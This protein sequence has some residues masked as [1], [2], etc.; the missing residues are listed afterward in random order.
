MNVYDYPPAG[1]RRQTSTQFVTWRHMASHHVTPR[2]TASHRRDRAIAGLKASRHGSG[3]SS[4][5]SRN[6]I[7]IAAWIRTHQ[8]HS[9]VISNA[10]HTS[11]TTSKPVGGKSR[12]TA[13][14]PAG[15]RHH[16]RHR[17]QIRNRIAQRAREAPCFRRLHADFGEQQRKRLRL[18]IDGR[19]E[20]ASTRPAPRSTARRAASARTA[21]IERG[22]RSRTARHTTRPGRSRRQ[23]PDSPRSAR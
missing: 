8:R 4:S 18:A 11:T 10:A 22:K 20:T 13:R 12:R 21:S 5:V 14:P 16:R 19:R 2:H 17:H 6:A 3:C 1:G 15:T 9:T 7:C 23:A